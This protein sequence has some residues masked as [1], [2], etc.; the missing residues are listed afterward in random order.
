MDIRIM[1]GLAGGLGAIAGFAGW[2]GALPPNLM[3]G[4]RL[5]PWRAIMVFTAAAAIVLLGF[6]LRALGIHPPGR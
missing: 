1:L 3:K 6:S 5:I 4:P 2:R